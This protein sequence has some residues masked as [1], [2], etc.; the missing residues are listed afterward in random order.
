[1]RFTVLGDPNYVDINRRL[2]AA[3]NA[4]TP[5]VAVHRGQN[6]GSVVENTAKA[7]RAA[8]VSGADIVEIDV[9]ESTDG[10]FFTFHNGYEEAYFGLDRDILTL[11]TSELEE[12]QFDLYVSAE[13][14]KYGLERLSLILSSFPETILNIDRSWDCLLYTSPSPRDRQKSRMPSSA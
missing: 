12:L 6:A 11:S 8:I 13:A 7:V 4:R 9:I 2:L 3:A 5:L 14:E 10:D 1:M